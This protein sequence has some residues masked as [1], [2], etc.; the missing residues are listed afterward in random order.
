MHRD[1]RE[2]LVPNPLG[3]DGTGRRFNLLAQVVTLLAPWAI[4]IRLGSP[5]RQRVRLDQVL[6]RLH[7]RRPTIQGRRRQFVIRPLIDESLERRHVPCFL[8]LAHRHIVAM[9]QPGQVHI[10]KRRPIRVLPMES[11]QVLVELKRAQDRGICRLARFRSPLHEPFGRVEDRILRPQRKHIHRSGGGLFARCV[12]AQRL[13]R[14]E[15]VEG[16]PVA[17]R[18]R[19]LDQQRVEIRDRSL[20]QQ[21]RVH[22]RC[23]ELAIDFGEQPRHIPGREILARGLAGHGPLHEPPPVLLEILPVPVSL[24]RLQQCHHLGRRTL[25]FGP[26]PEDL[27][28]RL[29]ALNLTLHGQPQRDRLDRFAPGLLPHC[30]LL[31]R[32]QLL[33][34]RPR[35][36]FLERLI[37]F[38]PLCVAR[39]AE[40]GLQGHQCD[41]HECGYQDFH[42]AL[43][44]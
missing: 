16:G 10:Q 43:T 14:D 9:D 17:V 36:T 11:H 21:I 20:L 12:K 40:C 33:N 37:D 8:L 25:Q 23:L 19:T 26:H 5:S 39:G 7:D 15:I 18:Q 35:Q 30:R 3:V 2:R 44:R 1:G 34:R 31:D 28:L 24:D 22:Q 38:L 32:S 27:F 41:R 6:F 4:R 42:R 29:V 13:V